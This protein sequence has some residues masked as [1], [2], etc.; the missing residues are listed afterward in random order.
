MVNLPGKVL[1]SERQPGAPLLVTALLPPEIQAWADALRTAHFPPERNRLR[2]HVT[3]FHALPPSVEEELI[4]V[5]KDLTRTPPAQ[6]QVVG[7]LK[8]G[9]GTAI[10]I[11]SPAMVECHA[12]IAARMHG[13]LTRQDAQ[14]LRL[15][16]TI[17][18]KVTSQEARAL[19][20]QLSPMLEPRTFRFRGFGIYAWEDGLWRPIKDLHFNR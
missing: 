9:K 6:A 18:N 15:H 3:L 16:I 13:L 19:Q 8:L 1:S 10:R 14:P 2:A 4:Q 7:L 12:E 5:L 20:A 17:Q 11:E